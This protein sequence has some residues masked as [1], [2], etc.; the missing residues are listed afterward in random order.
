MVSVPLVTVLPF[1][2]VL[3]AGFMT[4]MTGFGFSVLAVPL[5]VLTYSPHDVVIIVLCLVPVTS[6]ALL[7]AP[8]LRGRVNVRLS[9][10]LSALSVV[11][12]PIGVWL[13]RRYDPAVLTVLMGAVILGFAVF[14]LYSAQEWR[15]PRSL[16]IPSG[17]LGGLLATSTGLSGPAV[18]MYV[19]GRRLDHDQLVATMA[20]YVG[21]VSLLGL[22][23]LGVQGQVTSAALVGVLPLVPTSLIGVA[24]GCWWSKKNHRA[25]ERV[26]LQALGAMGLWTLVRAFFG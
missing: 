18:A 7:L 4:G 23:W 6:V 11:G 24:L 13:F 8:H 16:V 15:L 1:V 10:G 12:L 2:V 19:H 22:G 14:N 20:T 17:I 9:S 3:I 5:L 21:V 26:A 25:I